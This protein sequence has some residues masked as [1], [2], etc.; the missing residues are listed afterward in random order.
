MKKIATYSV[1]TLTYLVLQAA[2]EKGKDPEQFSLNPLNLLLTETL[3]GWIQQI[4]LREEYDVIDVIIIKNDIFHELKEGN[5]LQN[6]S[7][8][9][10]EILADFIGEGY[11]DTSFYQMAVEFTELT[12]GK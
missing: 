3:M 11:K 12:D 4:D 8:P 2:V 9:F 7:E 1:E 10:L 5:Y 6:G